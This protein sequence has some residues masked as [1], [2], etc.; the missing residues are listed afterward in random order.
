MRARVP[1]V[2]E[3]PRP[4]PA[5]TAILIPRGRPLR[6]R[7]GQAPC[8]LH[9]LGRAATPIAGRSD[10]LS[11][12][13]G[14]GCAGGARCAAQSRL[15]A[16]T[17]RG[18]GTAT[19]DSGAGPGLH[20][21]GA[22]KAG[23][24]AGRPRVTGGRPDRT[25][26]RA[27]QHPGVDRVGRSLPCKQDLRTLQGAPRWRLHFKRFLSP[28]VGGPRGPLRRP[29]VRRGCSLRPHRPLASSPCPSG[30]RTSP[31]RRLYTMAFLTYSTYSSIVYL[32]PAD[33]PASMDWSAL[34]TSGLGPS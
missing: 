27:R 9:G 20:A 29:Q 7:N 31:Q 3:R 16:R 17:G 14:G 4:A 30:Q 24:G 5:P 1:A 13:L 19:A 15:F 33:V 23:C 18:G 10:R 32:L 25:A 34:S 2:H 8:A 12:R 21:R 11:R 26:A 22:E 6:Q 28:G